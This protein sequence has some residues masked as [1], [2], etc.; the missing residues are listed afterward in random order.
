MSRYQLKHYFRP[1]WTDLYTLR[2]FDNE[3]TF[4]SYETPIVFQIPR[5]ANKCVNLSLLK[6]HLRFA[7][8]NKNAGGAA[9]TV[10][11]KKL[12]TEKEVDTIIPGH[13]LITLFS[14]VKLKLNDVLVSASGNQYPTTASFLLKSQI[15]S[16]FRDFMA[17]AGRGYETDTEDLVAMSATDGK[18]GEKIDFSKDKWKDF[19]MRA[20]WY[21]MHRKEFIDVTSYVI[22]DINSA[23]TPLILPDSTTVNL[24][25]VLND[26]AKAIIQ[27]RVGLTHISPT[28]EIVEARLSVPL[29]IPRPGLPKT[30][31]HQFMSTKVQPIILSKDATHYYGMSAYHKTLPSRVSLL[32]MK[33]SQFDG[34]GKSS[35]YSSQPFDLENVVLYVGGVPYPTQTVSAAFSKGYLSE[36]WLRTGE[37][38]RLSLART[39]QKMPSLQRY[40]EEDFIYSI[41]LSADYRFFHFT[42]KAIEETK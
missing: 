24:E 37:S 2:Y 33:L 34:D 9:P 40:R 4:Q 38:L 32:F 13:P 31:K 11:G 36:M 12:A 26:P 41:D 15:P 28:I 6:L 16:L 27:S 5:A 7:V 39:G 3:P 19:D 23:Q 10:D 21:S 35:I 22:L 14:D 18:G 25:F 1:E 17:V 30:V 20:A 29:H 8:R 42:R